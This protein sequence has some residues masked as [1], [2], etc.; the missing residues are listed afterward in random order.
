MLRGVRAGVGLLRSAREV[1][2][3]GEAW[4]TLTVFDMERHCRYEEGEQRALRRETDT[5]H[6]ASTE[7]LWRD[8]WHGA[9]TRR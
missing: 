5:H 6:I 2:G 9:W 3:C 1:R 7:H 4:A 8:L